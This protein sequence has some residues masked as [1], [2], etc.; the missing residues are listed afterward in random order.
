MTRP[1]VGFE[2]QSNPADGS[3]LFTRIVGLPSPLNFGDGI[4]ISLIV[5]SLIKA[6]RGCLP[7]PACIERHVERVMQSRTPLHQINIVLKGRFHRYYLFLSLASLLLSGCLNTIPAYPTGHVTTQTPPYVHASPVHLLLKQPTRADNVKAIVDTTGLAH[8]V[9]GTSEGNDVYYVLLGPDG[10]IGRELITSHVADPSVDAAFDRAGRL[11][12]LIGSDHLIKEERSWMPSER[13]PW[14]EAGLTPK[15]TSFVPGAHELTW[16]FLIKGDEI[17]TAGRW[18]VIGGSAFG[19]G[20]ISPR[21][22]QA[23]K[24]LIV[25]E[26]APTYKTWMVLEPES[27]HDTTFWAFGVDS[28]GAIHLAYEQTHVPFLGRVGEV[29]Y[30][31]ILIDHAPLVSPATSSDSTSLLRDRRQ[32]QAI[33]G[34]RGLGPTMWNS[35]PTGGDPASL[36]IHT[37]PPVSLAVDPNSGAALI[38]VKGSPSS[39]VVRDEDWSPSI[40]PPLSRFRESRVA[41][42]GKDR[43]HAVVVVDD[44]DVGGGYPLYYLDFNGK[45]W[46]PPLRLGVANTWGWAEST[47]SNAVQIASNGSPRAVLVWPTKEGIVGRWIELLQ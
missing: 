37:V 12:V 21:Y 6:L 43:F 34:G 25:P 11:H 18:D 45:T 28:Q 27:N 5:S 30:K 2:C 31:K 23:V 36:G 26:T 20:G 38:V 32:L 33:S 41:S 46:S 42:S 9:I 10:V 44:W 14:R 4:Y 3:W 40:P 1:T 22:T 7:G 29:R 47:V 39:Y 24:L 8:I 19:F 17:G 16:A 13:T 35:G 15:S